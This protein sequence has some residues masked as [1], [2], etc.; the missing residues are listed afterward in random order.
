MRGVLAI[1]FGLAAFVW[2][3]VTLVALVLLFGVYALVDAVMALVSGL[4]NR[5]TP[6]WG[7]QVFEGFVGIIAGVLT[8][9]APDIAA[10]A[11]LYLI[12]AWAFVTGILE[13]AAA[14]QLRREIEDEWL[15]GFSGLLSLGLGIATVFWPAAS[16]LA[17]VWLIGAYAIVFG[18][19]LIALGS[20]LRSGSQTL[21]MGRAQPA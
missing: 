12:A 15:L 7:W 19:A 9:L 6:H 1:L 4:S 2:P 8:F 20:R 16:A 11:F 5:H 14:I 17:V 18:I 10:A 21:G 13:I 3:G